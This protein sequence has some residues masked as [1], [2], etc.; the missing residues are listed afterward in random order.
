VGPDG[1]ALGRVSAIHDHGAGPVVEI[2]PPEGPS[3]LVSFTREHVPTVDIDGGRMVVA[4]AEE[5]P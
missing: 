5:G 2:Q 3:I 4:P 1:D